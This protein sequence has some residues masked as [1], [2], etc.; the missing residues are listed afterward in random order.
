MQRNLS[1]KFQVSVMARNGKAR[2][3]FPEE[4]SQLIPE[5]DLVLLCVSDSAV[6]EVSN[7]IPRTSKPIVHV[8]GATP[9]S[10]ISAQ[11]LHRGI[12]YPLM[13]FTS[14]QDPEFTSIPFCLEASDADTMALI[15]ELTHSMGATSYEVDSEQRK[16]L[17]LAAVLSQNFSNHLFQLA[18]EEMEKAGL[19][20]KLIKP[21]LIQ[22]VE[23]LGS[24]MPKIMQ[25]G[26]AVR[27]DQA[28]ISRHEAMI[29]DPLTLEIYRLMTKSIQ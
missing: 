24:E 9:M 15:K 21:L 5:T 25:T 22:S 12:W 20:F 11:H 16:A 18:F 10:S 23:R 17:H 6:N 2:F 28:T 1:K 13:S 4:A 14:A 8:S 7:S 3:S 26:P 29:N 27:N 19:D